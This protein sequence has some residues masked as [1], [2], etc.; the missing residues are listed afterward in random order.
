[1][2]P[3]STTLLA[4]LSLPLMAAACGND[5]ASPED[6]RY[7]NQGQVCLHLAEDAQNTSAIEIPSISVT[8]PICLSSSCSLNP[9]ASCTASVEGTTI[10]LS[11]E[12]SFLDYSVTDRACTEDCGQLQ[13]RC[14][15][16]ALEAGE[17]TVIHGEETF[18]LEVNPAEEPTTCHGARFQ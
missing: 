7:E 2:R 17:Y 14:A 6:V 10:T 18:T 12:A 16:P 1:M 9:E 4:L 5:D 3:L 8:I 15:I 11:S 13:A